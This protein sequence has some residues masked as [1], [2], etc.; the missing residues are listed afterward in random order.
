MDD[1]ALDMDFLVF[2]G[3]MAGMTAAARAADAGRR[4][5][6][7]EKG[8]EIGGSA[9]LSGGKLWTAKTI[10]MFEQET[11]GGDPTLRAAV[12]ELFE[13]AVAWLRS[14]GVAVADVSY[15]LHYGTGYDFDI[16]GYIDF[17]RRAVEHAGG[18]VIRN[19]SADRL[20]VEG[21]RVR[22]AVI[23]DADGETVVHAPWTLLAT[24][25]FSAN[26]GLLECFVHRRAVAALARSNPHSTGD[27]LRLGLAAGAA[28]SPFMKGFYGHV[29]Q[30]PVQKWGPRE[31]RA[32][33]Q[34]GSIR[35]IMINRQGKRFC[36]ESLG[37]HQNAQRILEQPGARVLILFDEAVRRQ[38]A[39]TVLA[40]T[41][42]PIDKVQIAIDEG[43][44]V[45]VAD[46]WEALFDQ[47][48]SWGFDGDAGLKTIHTHNAAV[49][50]GAAPPD[51]PRVRDYRSYVTPPFYAVEGQ[52]GITATHGGLRVDRQARVLNAE[53]I[54]IPG[55]LAA[56]ADAGNVYGEGYA[57]GLAFAATFALLAAGHVIET[58][59]RG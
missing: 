57:G 8:P 25:G 35:G 20:L 3:G 29:I 56:G 52:T 59:F 53:G 28:I 33:T 23:I 40:G 14:T 46:S 1:E 11:P 6:V 16:V 38:E 45:A 50:D 54:P 26:P 32:Y 12:F 31:F 37:D 41:K 13:Q 5:L 18:M 42:T 39:A 48:R 7:V 30:S 44:H 36:D 43:A 22:G 9:V 58:P 55:L 51:F 27:G 49:H 15:H 21:G 4:V 10:E 24:G 19:A 2:G 17:C 34:G 47:V